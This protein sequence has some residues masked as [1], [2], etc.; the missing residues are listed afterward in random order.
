M[1]SSCTIRLTTGD[2]RAG[3]TNACNMCAHA[4]PQFGAHAATVVQHMH[5]ARGKL[6]GVPLKRSVSFAPRHEVEQLAVQTKAESVNPHV[7]CSRSCT[8]L[9]VNPRNKTSATAAV[10]QTTAHKNTVRHTKTQCNTMAQPTCEPQPARGLKGLCYLLT[11]ENRCSAALH[12]G[13]SPHGICSAV[14]SVAGWLHACGNSS[15]QRRAA[16]KKPQHFPCCTQSAQTLQNVPYTHMFG[17]S[18]ACHLLSS[19]SETT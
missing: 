16:G 4:V 14:R 3:H 5:M 8:I 6:E 17:N 10:P 2:P 7:H 9:V 1:H 15:C 19:S 12:N 13:I 11:Q 18:T